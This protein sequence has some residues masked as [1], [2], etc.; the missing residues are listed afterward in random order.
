[1]RLVSNKLC[2]FV[3]LSLLGLYGIQTYATTDYMIKNIEPIAFNAF[4]CWTASAREQMPG[5]IINEED[6]QKIS[7]D[8]KAVLIDAME[9]LDKQYDDPE[10]LF[11]YYKAVGY[12]EGFVM[13]K[14]ST[15]WSFEYLPLPPRLDY[16]IWFLAFRQYASAH[17]ETRLRVNRLY[18]Y[19]KNG[20]KSLGDVFHLKDADLESESLE[21]HHIISDLQAEINWENFETL[22][23]SF[24]EK[25]IIGALSDQKTISFEEGTRLF[26][27]QQL[28][29]LYNNR[30]R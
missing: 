25:D 1:M 9:F 3:K 24:F 10:D 16:Q 28:D 8:F 19:M 11:D 5:L 17:E 26:T 13:G 22:F 29:E 7:A 18:T 15:Q 2:W 14:I 23:D 30:K 20:Q 4:R 27:D 21:A 12:I 6:D